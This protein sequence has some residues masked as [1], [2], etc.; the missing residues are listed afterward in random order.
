MNYAVSPRLEIL[1]PVRNATE[2]FARTIAS[3]TTQTDRNFSVLISDNFSSSGREHIS[4]ALVELREAGLAARKI[5]P[6]SELG[7]VEHWNWLHYQSQ[8]EWLKPLFAGDWLE[9]DYIA[10]VSTALA[11]DSR[12]A[13]VFCGYQHHHGD[14]THTSIPQWG[15]GRYHTPEEMQEIVLRYAMQFGPPSVAA[16]Q[17]RIFLS[18]GGYEP[19]LPISADSLLYCKF[20]ARHGAYG[21]PRACA[22]FLIHTARFSDTLPKKQ[23]E[24]F[25]ETMRY[26]AELGVTAWHEHWRFPK[27]GYVRLFARAIRD[28]WKTG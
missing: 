28:R 26:F 9:P 23:R 7:R 8:A 16:Y 20:A 22:H 2:V 27:L 6:P 24:T 13:Y 12:C 5:E 4:H 10:A 14:K 21:I 3:L 17:R 11:S 18:S 19:T 1:I 15:V 25:R